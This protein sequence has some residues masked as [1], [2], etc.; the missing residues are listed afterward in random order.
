MTAIGIYD[1]AALCRDVINRAHCT[2]FGI[3]QLALLF[4]WS[5]R[6]AVRQAGWGKQLSYVVAFSR[7]GVTDVMRRYTKQWDEL[8][9]HRTLVSEEWL[10]QQCSSLTANHRR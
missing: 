1:T 6:V 2:L 10:S 8:R 3:S 4:A 9:R 5:L 7:H